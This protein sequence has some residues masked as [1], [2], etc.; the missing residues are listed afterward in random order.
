MFSGAAELHTGDGSIFKQH[1]ISCSDTGL[2]PT[3]ELQSVSSLAGSGAG[4][5]ACSCAAAASDAVPPVSAVLYSPSDRAGLKSG[6]D[7]VTIALS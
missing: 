5:A 7:S 3:L 6:E 1:L 2:L 4:T